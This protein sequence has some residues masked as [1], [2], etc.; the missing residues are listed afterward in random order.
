MEDTSKIDISQTEKQ[1]IRRVTSG[2]ADS[3]SV[4]VRTHYNSVYAMIMRQVGDSETACDLTQDT[5]VQAYLKLHTFECRSLFSTWI[6]RIALNITNSYFSSA[7]FK[8]RLSTI[9]FEQDKHEQTQQSSASDTYDETAYT[10]LQIAISELPSKYRNVLTLCSLNNHSYIE[11]AAILNIP[12]GTVR[13]RL[14]TARQ[15]LQKLYFRV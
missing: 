1:I 9:R 14:N 8:K 5:F 11:A 6:I 2:D 7:Q 10:K 4:L 3:F 12:V 13:S 15:K